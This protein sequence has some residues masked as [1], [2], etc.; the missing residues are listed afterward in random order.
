MTILQSLD[1]YYHRLPGVAEPG[2][3]PIKFG[4]C[5][6]LN[7]EGQPVDL[8]DL[9]DLLGKKPKLK[10]YLVPWSDEVAKRTSGIVANLFADKTAYVLGRTAGEGKRTANEHGAFVSEHLRMLDGQED[11]GLIALRRFLEDWQPEG[12]ESLPRFTP[13]MLDSNIMFRLEREHSFLHER[14]AARTLLASQDSDGEGSAGNEGFCLIT[15]EFGPIA[16]LHR[17]IKGVENAQSSGAPLVSCNSKESPAFSSYYKDQ[18]LL[19][20]TG[21]T[22]AFRY[23]TALNH[24]LTRDGPNRLRRPVGDATVVYWADASNAKAA[25]D[26]DILFAHL[27][28]SD[29]TDEDQAAKV[30]DL[31][32]QVA[33][34]RPL[35]ELRP[36]IEPGTRFHVL[37][38][39]PNAARLSVRF[40]L[41]D[42][43]DSFAAR[44]ARHQADLSIEPPPHN[45]GAAPSVNRLLVNTAAAQRDFKNIP[46]L[47]AGEVMRAVLS[48]G[49]YPQ[50]L[51]SAAIIRLRAG[52]NAAS[53]W[54][55]AVIRA[56][57]VRQGRRDPLI[58]EQGETPMSLKRDHANP[59]Y[60]LGRLFAVYE[61]AQRAALGNIN[62]TIRD[63]Y[64]GAA[65]AT[66]A[67][68]FPLIVRGGMNHLAKVR[69]DKPGWAHLIE[70]ELEEINDRF[71]PRPDGIWPRSLRLQDQGEFAIGYYHQ[72][73]AKLTNDKGEA[74]HADDLPDTTDLE[75]AEQ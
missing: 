8:E 23:T 19:S 36:E 72:R 70:R 65:S 6:V 66:P 46:P 35:A 18:G 75:G 20:P 26:A 40:W 49:R 32:K 38:L 24:L 73:A 59:G 43:L 11:E 30:R 42:T 48:G 67:S 12:L 3:A 4:W 25:E 14:P 34:G 15:G 22:A 71:D 10:D 44:L 31:M 41:S 69:K 55:A 52:D 16:R 64:F 61:L 37:G 68:V 58:P 7:R 27:L 29:A 74:V 9:R 5:I 63:R 60:Q 33:A 62:A 47:L 21:K 45:W 57:L 28:D 17:S 53:G 50:S 54:H 56:V 13:D 2:W 39:S 51:L 1:S